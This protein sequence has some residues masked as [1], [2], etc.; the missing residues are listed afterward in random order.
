[1]VL[2]SDRAQEGF[3]ALILEDFLQGKL[4]S[5]PFKGMSEALINGRG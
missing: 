1:M 2:V 3:I 4:K 5:A